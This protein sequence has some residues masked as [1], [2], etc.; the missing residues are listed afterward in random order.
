MADPVGM[1]EA[2]KERIRD[3]LLFAL[4]A[5]TVGY[6]WKFFY[7]LS[8]SKEGP[9][10]AIE[11]ALRYWDSIGRPIGTALL[12]A[13]G[14]PLVGLVVEF[15][16]TV[17]AS[18]KDNAVEW[19]HNRFRKLTWE[20]LDEHPRYLLERKLHQETNSLMD[21]GW[22]CADNALGADTSTRVMIHPCGRG[23]FNFKLP[24]VA[25]TRHDQLV[26]APGPEKFTGEARDYYL[27]T[28]RFDDD[29][30]V[31]VW[32]QSLFRWPWLDDDR[33]RY[34]VG[35]DLTVHQPERQVPIK[36]ERVALK[37]MGKVSFDGW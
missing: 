26:P 33:P 11:H 13:F 30:V 35:D 5:S 28:H 37:D 6:N 15:V 10:K 14:Y 23:D 7:V 27:V 25:V 34:W 2:W 16:R 29:H 20:R 24:A 36:L 4:A 17:I 31:A 19:A 8:A 3:P 9:D 22:K 18:W 32:M 12:F 21:E 1:F